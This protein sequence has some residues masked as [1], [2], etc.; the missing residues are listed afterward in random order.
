MLKEAS[1]GSQQ[2]GYGKIILMI[3]ASA[4]VIDMPHTIDMLINT[5]QSWNETV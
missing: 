2:T 5:I 3:F 4:L 1:E